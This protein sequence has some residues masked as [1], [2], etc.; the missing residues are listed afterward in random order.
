MTSVIDWLNVEVLCTRQHIMARV[1]NRAF[2]GLPVCAWIPEITNRIK[3][4]MND[5][6]DRSQSRLPRSGN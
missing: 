2:V 5:C 3:W 6:Y 4:L 1:S